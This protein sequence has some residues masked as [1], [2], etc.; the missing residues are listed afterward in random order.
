MKVKSVNNLNYQTKKQ[1]HSQPSFEAR[2]N[3]SQQRDI[4]SDSFV[5]L[6][7]SPLK[8]L[9]EKIKPVLEKFDDNLNIEISGVTKPMSFWDI[10]RN[11]RPTGL[12]F[13]V[14]IFDEKKFVN[15]ILNDKLLPEFVEPQVIQGLKNKDEVLI[16]TGL[17]RARACTGK[18][19][20]PQKGETPEQY[21][22]EV[23]PKLKE[24]IRLMPKFLFEREGLEYNAATQKF[25]DKN[26]G[27]VA[28]MKRYPWE[29]YRGIEY[30][31]PP[32]FKEFYQ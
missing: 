25:I 26:R 29:L 17:R 19:F 8:Q 1:K 2:V 21:I 6:T 15:D 5:N 12:K 27:Y 32:I 20:S 24:H 10:F 16:R 23:V 31:Y 22:A 13:D 4:I 11:T 28:G 18:Y 3:I 7:E 14:T 30:D 9:V